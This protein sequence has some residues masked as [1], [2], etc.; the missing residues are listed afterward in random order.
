MIRRARETQIL[1]RLVCALMSIGLIL[2]AATASAQ[3]DDDDDWEEEGLYSQPGGYVT[4]G[5]SMGFPNFDDVV[6]RPEK[7]KGYLWDVDDV[8]PIGGGINFKI[9]A[10]AI[11]WIAYEFQFEWISAMNFDGT[12]VTRDDDP[13]D[14]DSL[15]RDRVKPNVFATTFNAKIFPLHW[16]LDGVMGGRIQPYVIGGFGMVA[17]TKTGIN[18]PL[19]LACRGA[20]GVDFWMNETWSLYAEAG[21]VYTWG[22]LEGLNYTSLSLGGTYHF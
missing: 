5:G 7:D 16:W 11:E 14:V 15:P 22:N 4:L 18:T 10:R 2:C 8:D 6:G 9:G 3:D 20:G 13:D 17:A 21:Y 19:S 12:L 1:L